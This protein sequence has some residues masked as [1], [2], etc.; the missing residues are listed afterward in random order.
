MQSSILSTKTVRNITRQT[1]IYALLIGIGFI[2]MIPFL[3]M[4]STSLK[5][6]KDVWKSPPVWI[7]GE[8]VWR[9]YIDA[10]TILPFYIYLKNTLTIT[11]L[12]VFGRVFSASV[13]GFSFARL[14]W[15]G[16][17]VIFIVLLST[18]MLPNQITLIPTFIMFRFFGWVNTFKPLI[19]PYFFGTAFDIFL[20]RQFLATIPLELEDAA[21]IDGCGTFRIYWNI[22]MPMAKPVLAAVM[23]FA[24]MFHWNQFMGPL[25]YL[26]SANKRTLA[27]GLRAFQAIQEQ[28]VTEWHLLMAAS[29]GVLMPCLIIFFLAQ[30]FF[31]QGIV[32]TGVKG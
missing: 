12:A 27:L 19:V 6:L 14:H 31:I 16:R 2:L 25:I 9:N 5:E 1:V 30:K 4:V 17:N 15:R 3:W 8:P 24:F 23:I 22:I 20:V 28:G 29:L 26:N 11:L 10:F 18:M 32:V 7:P 13:G 21:K